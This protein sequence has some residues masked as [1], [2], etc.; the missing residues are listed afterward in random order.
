MSK[1]KNV[2]MAVA[3]IVAGCVCVYAYIQNNGYQK[4][5]NNVSK[6]FHSMRVLGDG[7]FASKLAQSLLC[8]QIANL[9]VKSS[10]NELELFR[11]SLGDDLIKAREVW[12]D[13]VLKNSKGD[14]TDSETSTY[15][16]IKAK[17]SH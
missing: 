16:K 14:L 5:L 7:A 2:S 13:L 8:D 17:K 9:G 6:D 11:E 1:I 3:L 12:T 4:L 15:S 10:S